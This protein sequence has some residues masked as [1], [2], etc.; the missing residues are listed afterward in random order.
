MTSST[1]CSSSTALFCAL[2]LGLGCAA[3]PAPRAGAAGREHV[4]VAVLPPDNM[5]AGAVPT[6]E[7]RAA[8]ELALAR[9]GVD[10][11]SGELVERYLAKHR[12]RY[13]GGIDGAA[14]QAAG[15]DM[16]VDH[17]IITNVEQYVET[18]PRL[19]LTLRLVGATAEAPLL[20]VDGISR[21][22]N[23]SPGLLGLGLIPD[24][25]SLERAVLPALADS[26]VR[27]LENRGPAAPQCP[28]GRR[29]RPKIPYR[30]PLLEA[31]KTY[32]VAV[33]P[34]RNLTTRRFAGDVL[35]LT[36]ARQMAA[37]PNFK[38]IEPGVVRELLLRF[39]IIMEGGVSV[40]QVRSIVGTLGA[41]LVVAGDVLEFDAGGAPRLNFT[42]SV[43]DG[44]SNRTVWQS[45]SYNTGDDGV[46]FYDVGRVSTASSLACRMVRTAVDGML[47]AKP[48]ATPEL[49]SGGREVPR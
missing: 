25:A 47:T 43:L 16:G 28:D 31:N 20:W 6:R 21:A 37:V 30:S 26:L 48:T 40:D 39:R 13:T 7:L 44:H 45:T 24:M 33:V 15:E 4:R 17:V 2:A 29:F 38:V 5:S 41:D 8:I 22:G 36:F 18:P 10:V 19:A 34:F 42:V 12:L 27:H 11:V 9:R 3:R 46:F 23:E 49:P 35:A 1:S 14:A 32:S